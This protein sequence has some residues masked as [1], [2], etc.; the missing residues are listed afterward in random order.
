MVSFFLTR[1]KAR[2]FDCP[3]ITLVTVPTELFAVTH[4]SLLLDCHECL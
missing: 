1:I 3:A 4:M 2:L